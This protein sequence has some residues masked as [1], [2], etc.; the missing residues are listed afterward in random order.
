MDVNSRQNIVIRRENRAYAYVN[1]KTNKR[2]NQSKLLDIQEHAQR[3]TIGPTCMNI[4]PSHSVATLFGTANP[5]IRKSSFI[6]K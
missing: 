5:I 1:K 4:A 2:E 6:N 3:K